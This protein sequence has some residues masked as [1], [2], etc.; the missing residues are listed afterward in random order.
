MVTTKHK[1]NRVLNHQANL[2][3]GSK[4][5]AQLEHLSEEK[6]L[7]PVSGIYPPRGWLKVLGYVVAFIPYCGFLLG[8]IYCSQPDLAAKQFGRH[9]IVIAAIGCFFW[10]ISGLLKVVGSTDS[11][12]FVGGYF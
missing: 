11:T 4:R 8:I 6:V 12:G 7:S 2:R 3:R 9:C 5:K 10:G 1:A